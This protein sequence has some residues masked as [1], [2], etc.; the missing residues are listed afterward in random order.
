MKANGNKCLVW[1]ERIRTGILELRPPRQNDHV[2]QTQDW[3]VHLQVN[4][5]VY[6]SITLVGFTLARKWNQC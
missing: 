5:Q 3:G 1:L 6:Y 2:T 4:I